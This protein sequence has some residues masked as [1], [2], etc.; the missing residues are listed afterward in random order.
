[1]CFA[2]S[3]V[4]K[5]EVRVARRKD[6]KISFI[7]NWETFFFWISWREKQVISLPSTARR[8]L[9]YDYL[10]SPTISISIH[11]SPTHRLFLLFHFASVQLWS[12]PMPKANTNIQ[13]MASEQ[14]E[15]RWEHRYRG[16]KA[17]WEA[18]FWRCAHSA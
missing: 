13:K 12:E 15:M 8:I 1:M 7:I 9:W 2:M 16:L 3:F 17:T 4:C 11:T 5:K 10:H 18:T 14:E 6:H